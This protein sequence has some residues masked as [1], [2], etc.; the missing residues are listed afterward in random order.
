MSSLDDLNK[1]TVDHAA[2]LTEAIISANEEQRAALNESA[3]AKAK[4][5]RKSRRSSIRENEQRKENQS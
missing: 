5:T 4:K 2:A 3:R 1:F